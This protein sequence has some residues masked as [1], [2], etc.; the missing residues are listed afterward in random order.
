[1][2][3]SRTEYQIKL[4]SCSL[5][6][7]AM[8]FPEDIDEKVADYAWRSSSV[9]LALGMNMMKHRSCAARCSALAK[10]RTTTV[11]Q[12]DRFLIH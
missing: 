7:H 2:P 3:I 8:Q 4:L 1:M 10:F 6:S 9:Y 5:L 11:S 12:L